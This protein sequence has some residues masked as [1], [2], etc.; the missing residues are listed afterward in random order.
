MTSRHLLFAALIILS[1]TAT[2]C[3]PEERPFERPT[4]FEVVEAETME[5]RRAALREARGLDD[6]DPFDEES[7]EG[8][9]GFVDENTGREELTVE[10]VPDLPPPAPR[11]QRD[12]LLDALDD[13]EAR[14]AEEERIAEWKRNNP[15]TVTYKEVYPEV[16]PREEYKPD[17]EGRIRRAEQ[18]DGVAREMGYT[19]ERSRTITQDDTASLGVTRT[20][21]DAPPEREV[22]PFI[23][24]LPPIPGLPAIGKDGPSAA[25]LSEKGDS[26]TKATVTRPGE[27]RTGSGVVVRP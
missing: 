12:P 27:L 11:P 24:G 4:E 18:T 26:K 15:P 2:G 8:G 17:P 9:G 3:E 19:P 25:G 21:S 16:E 10:R 5:D 7:G 20:Q 6:E 23:P 1:W 14:R 13:F 22:K